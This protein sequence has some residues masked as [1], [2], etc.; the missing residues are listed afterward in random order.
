MFG[1]GRWH[2]EIG[3]EF[4]FHRSAAGRAAILLRLLSRGRRLPRP[5]S[6]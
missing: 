1:Q 6:L 2:E 5:P 3:R 4:Q